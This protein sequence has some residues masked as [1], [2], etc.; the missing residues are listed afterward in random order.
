MDF[1]IEREQEAVDF[2]INLAE[3]SIDAAMKNV[4]IQFSREEMGHK[5]RLINIKE[6]GLMKLPDINV[7]DLQIADYIVDIIPRAEMTYQ[8]ALVMAMKKRENCI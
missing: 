1:A 5:A 2:Y 8:E 7:Q 3:K 6:N 4:F